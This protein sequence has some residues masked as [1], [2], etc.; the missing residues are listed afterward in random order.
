MKAIILKKYGGI[1]QLEMVETKKPIIGDDELLVKMKAANIA[2]GDMRIHTQDAPGIPKFVMSLIF[3]FKKPRRQIRGISGSGVIET[4]GSKVSRYKKGDEIYF[5]NSMK[6]GCYGEYVALREQSV[7][8][9]K[10]Q[11]ISFEEAAPLAFGAMSAYHFINS[12]TIKP[13]DRVLIFGASG[14]VG[15]Y[16]AQLAMYYGAHVTA[17]ASQKHHE[18]LRAVGIEKFIDYQVKDFRREKETYDVIFDAVMKINKKSCKHLLNENGKYYSIKSPT[19]EEVTRLLAINEIIKK[20]QLH[21]VID[22]IYAYDEFREAHKKV[23]DNHKTGNVVLK[24]G[25]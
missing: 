12:K 21:T 2:S 14:S 10:P 16:A 9:K 5:I 20:D 4:I 6:A 13:G 7:I 3:G 17:V 18:K 24:I 22:Q 25:K 1:D 19:K 11:N 23:Y 15:S 8:A